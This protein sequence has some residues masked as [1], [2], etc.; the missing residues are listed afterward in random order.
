MCKSTGA[1]PRPRPAQQRGRECGGEHTEELAC[2]P[3][4]WFLMPLSVARVGYATPTISLPQDHGGPGMSTRSHANDVIHGHMCGVDV[5]CVCCM[6]DVR[7]AREADEREDDGQEH[8]RNAQEQQ[9]SR[10]LGLALE[11]QQVPCAWGHAA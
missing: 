11:L 1:T 7:D 8:P 6:L 4:S 10:D 3:V 9:R 2:T 5:C